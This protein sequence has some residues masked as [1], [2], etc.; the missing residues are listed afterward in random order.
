MNGYGKRQCLAMSNAA[1][2]IAEARLFTI[3]EA[4]FTPA[5]SAK[6]SPNNAH[7]YM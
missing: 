7:E 4:Q 2:G 3:S 6:T 5:N 1:R